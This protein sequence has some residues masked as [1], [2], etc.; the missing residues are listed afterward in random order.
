MSLIACC[1]TSCSD[2]ESPVEPPIEDGLKEISLNISKQQVEVYDEPMTK[3]ASDDVY[4]IQLYN[5][6]DGK[7]DAYG[8]FDNVSNLKLTIKDN[9]KYTIA[10][11]LVPGYL[12]LCDF[13][14]NYTTVDNKFTYTALPSDFLWFHV[15]GA[16]AGKEASLLPTET[17]FMTHTINSGD[18]NTSYQIVLERFSSAIKLTAEGLDEGKIVCKIGPLNTNES[19]VIT[20]ELTPA[21]T[22]VESAISFTTQ[23]NPSYDLPVSIDYVDAAGTT[24]N[25]VSETYTFTTNKRKCFLL[26]SHDKDA[27]LSITKSNTAVE[28]E[29]EVVLGF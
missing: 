9:K 3:A 7:I 23:F 15:K 20:L 8:T 16:A 1:T 13:G 5:E 14:S 12:D 25:I 17:Y 29:E 27:G 21:A 18:T 26:K 10:A 2:S 4:Y 11:F 22:T 28:D 19:D 6:T 24:T